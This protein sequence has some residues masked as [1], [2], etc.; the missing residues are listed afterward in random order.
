MMKKLLSFVA[1]AGLLVACQPESLETAFEVGA[2]ELKVTV[3]VHDVN[4]PA[5]DIASTLYAG[6]DGNSLTYVLPETL[7]LKE[8][9]GVVVNGN[10]V[11]F[12]FVGQNGKAL[13]NGSIIF[14]A[15]YKDADPK[16]EALNFDKLLAG[17]VANYEVS[18]VVG[19]PVS[20]VT[21]DVKD[22]VG[23]PTTSVS[24]FN[25]TDGHALTDHNGKSWAKNLTEYLLSGTVVY[26]SKVGKFVD[27]SSIKNDS[28]VSAYRTAVEG[29]VKAYKAS[30]GSVTND[31]KFEFTVSAWSYYTVYQTATKAEHTVTVLA[32]EKEI[33]SFKYTD[34]ANQ[35]E[36]AEIANPEGHGHYVHGHGHSHGGHDNAGGGLV[37]PE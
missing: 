9:D 5:Q 27:E 6:E 4:S 20:E 12:S 36:Y 31:L 10:A 15:K 23:T 1:M 7:K 8:K 35:V 22:V 18:I 25:P 11:V 28:P 33:G 3:H 32:D 14:T 34:Y 37:F 19:K 13:S 2:P 21:F 16:S 17:G 29:Y 26:T 24:Y 30:Q